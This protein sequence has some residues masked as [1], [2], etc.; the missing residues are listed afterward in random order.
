MIRWVPNVSIAGETVRIGISHDL[1]KAMQR[2]D[3]IVW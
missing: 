1:Q 2:M 3:T